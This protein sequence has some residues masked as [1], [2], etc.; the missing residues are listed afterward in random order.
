MK[1]MNDLLD[2]EAIRDLMAR[3][4]QF[5]DGH[6][7]DLTAIYAEDVS[8]RSP[9]APLSG[10]DSVLT[11]IGPNPDRPVQFQ[12]FFTDLLISIDGDRASVF[13]NLL[14]QGFKPGHEP[15][16][17]RGLRSEYQ[18]VRRDGQWLIIEAAIVP[19]WEVGSINPA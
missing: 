16:N 9:V 5:M 11:R 15:H 19:M 14:V 2:R 18:L 8:L 10:R 4:T 7:G 12:H 17:S 13:A 6:G 3:N 1:D